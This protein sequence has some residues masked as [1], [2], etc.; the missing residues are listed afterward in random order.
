MRGRSDD[1]TNQDVIALASVAETSGNTS[2]SPTLTEKLCIK[3]KAAA[4][5]QPAIIT[6][7]AVISCVSPTLTG[8]QLCKVYSRTVP[9]TTLARVG[10]GIFPQQVALKALQMNAA[11][12]VKEH[13]SPWLA[14]GVVGVLQGVVYGQ[15]SVA[16]ARALKLSQAVSLAGMMRGAAFAGL[17]DVVSQGVPFMCSGHVQQ[18]LVEPLLGRTR[19]SS[20]EPSSMSRVLAVGLT[21]IGATFASQGFH[22]GQ[23]RMQSDLSLGYAAAIRSL[24]A[25]HGARVLVMGGSAR[26]AL[27]LLVNGLNEAVLR[28]AWERQAKS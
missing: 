9:A 18:A 20:A 21:S 26:V 3:A 8:W 16:Y 10:L 4:T 19:D 5:I 1:A 15:C 14:F 6:Y 22:N 17:R 11:T 12:P 27:L 7:G 23:I 24:W 2:I 25:E 28:P 13:L